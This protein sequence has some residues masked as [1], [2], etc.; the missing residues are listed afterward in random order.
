MNISLKAISR[1]KTSND[2]LCPKAFCPAM[3]NGGLFSG[4]ILIPSFDSHCSDRYIE[5]SALCIVK[6]D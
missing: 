6:V 5:R 3:P 2:T 1:G 4:T